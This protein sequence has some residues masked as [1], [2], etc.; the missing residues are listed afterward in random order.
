MLFANTNYTTYQATR[1]HHNKAEAVD[2]A[3]VAKGLADKSKPH[4]A[5]RLHCSHCSAI[6]IYVIVA[7]LM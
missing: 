6:A 1:K 3:C 7:K 5:G 4:D 2:A